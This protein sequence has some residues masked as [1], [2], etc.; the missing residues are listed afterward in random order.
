[1]TALVSSGDHGIGLAQFHIPSSILNRITYI[2]CT[3][4]LYT[5]IYQRNAYLAGH[6]RMLRYIGTRFEAEQRSPFGNAIREPHW[7]MMESFSDD[8][9]GIERTPGLAHAMA[10]WTQSLK[11]EIKA[12]RSAT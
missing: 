1:M 8:V 11:S 4:D 7:R 12:T 6:A 9:S 2:V 3:R 5:I 10:T